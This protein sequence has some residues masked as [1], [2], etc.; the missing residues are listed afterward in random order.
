M[1]G[2]IVQHFCAENYQFALGILKNEQELGKYPF[3]TAEWHGNIYFLISNCFCIAV[4]VE[5]LNNSEQPCCPEYTF[6]VSV[7]LLHNN[8]NSSWYVPCKALCYTFHIITVSWRTT[9]NLKILFLK[10]TD[11]NIFQWRKANFIL[12]RSYKKLTKKNVEYITHLQ[13][14]TFFYVILSFF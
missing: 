9:K 12:F 7:W 4:V 1:D 11:F 10:N 5:W 14:S 3:S 2:A 6:V 13:I 8:Q